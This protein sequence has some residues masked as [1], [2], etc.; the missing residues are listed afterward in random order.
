MKLV[1]TMVLDYGV[2]WV[3]EWVAASLFS[4]N[5]AKSALLLE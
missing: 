5:R 1:T 4:D 2:A 3:V